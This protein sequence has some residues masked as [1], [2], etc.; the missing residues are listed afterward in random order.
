MGF[1]GWKLLRFAAAIIG[2]LATL[3]TPAYAA[4][5]GDVRLS[6]SSS[7]VQI[8]SILVVGDSMAGQ[9]AAGL[10]QHPAKP[11]VE[12]VLSVGARY[13][14]RQSL[15]KLREH[16]ESRPVDAVVVMFGSWDVA[17]F[18]PGEFRKNLAS[19]EYRLRLSE[20]RAAIASAGVAPIW[21]TMPATRDI[22][23]SRDLARVNRVVRSVAR[24]FGDEVLAAGDVLDNRRRTFRR[25][26]S[27]RGG[28]VT[29]RSGDGLHLCAAGTLLVAD[30]VLSSLGRS[31]QL[32]PR[33]LVRAA[34]QNFLAGSNFDSRGC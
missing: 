21:V 34:K 7:D 3:A 2:L 27:L 9:L 23:L 15:A 32:R 33:R 8:E 31:R 29:V 22:T 19:G 10:R 6:K 14:S 25:K 17:S 16:I 4:P 26:V 24:E 30:Q 28:R 11:Q 5:L 20:W 12:F 1:W 13:Q 18:E